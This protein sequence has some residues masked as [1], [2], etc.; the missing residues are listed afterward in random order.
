MTVPLVT[1][2]AI[3]LALARALPSSDRQRVVMLSQGQILALSGLLEDLME[4]ENT[5]GL[6]V[7]SSAEMFAER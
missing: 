4:Q 6:E 3:R 1:L 7:S 2:G 5:A